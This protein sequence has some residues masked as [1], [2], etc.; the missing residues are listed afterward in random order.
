ML[1]LSLN[2]LA[3]SRPQMLKITS[4]QGV[5]RVACMAAGVPPEPCAWTSQEQSAA[6]RAHPTGGIG[7]VGRR[8][9]LRKGREAGHQI[10]G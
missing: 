6:G 8:A 2:C 4:S 7:G 3:V 1:R 10:N 9:A 5:H